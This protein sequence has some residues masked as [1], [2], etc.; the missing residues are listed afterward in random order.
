MRVEGGKYK[1]K[2]LQSSASG[3]VKPTARRVREGLFNYLGSQIEGVRVL[4]LCA[5]SGAVGIE[6][7]SRGAEHATFVDRSP[8]FCD[9]I[10]ANLETCGAP[11]ESA[12]VVTA[13]VIGF[14]Q[15]AR[16]A[17][18]SWDL[19]YYDPPYDEDYE[20]VLFELGTGNLLNANAGRF[21]V[22][23]LAERELP[24]AL[25][26]HVTDTLDYG[27]TRLTIVVRN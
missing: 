24:S 23:H 14:L 22:E 13:E 4:D 17:G 11:A 25:G 20:P 16:A 12:E 26:H 5:G 1:N 8:K 10:R 6:A 3:R 9:V 27:D 7:L 19:I 2:R 18:V 15:L 21:V